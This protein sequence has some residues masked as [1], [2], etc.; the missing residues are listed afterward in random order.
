[1]ISNIEM[2]DYTKAEQLVNELSE[3]ANDFDPSKPLAVIQTARTA[4]AMHLAKA[5]N[6]AVSG[7]AETAN[8][9]MLA[10][11]EI[12]P[13]NPALAEVSELIFSQSDVQ[14]RALVDF[15]QLLSQRNYRQI[16]DDRVRL[17]AATSTDP[18]KARQLQ[19]VLEEMAMIEGAILRAQEIEKRGDYVGA[20]ES[21]ERAYQQFPNDNKLNSV[22]AD[23][24]TK[25]A[26]FVRALRTAEEMEE[27]GQAGS[28]LA[29]FLRAQSQYPPSD[30]AREGIHRVVSVIMPD[31]T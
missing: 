26:D 18:D 15:D 9:E 22:R 6:A 5:K 3:M 11:G 17:I 21:V 24:T 8:A 30:F 4:S 1:L 13:R 27:R 14:Q 12:W 19:E 25:A 28:S 31:A 10:A 20:W 7:D 23:L 29:W 2:R 16:Y